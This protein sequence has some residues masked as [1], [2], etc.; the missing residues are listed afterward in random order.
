VQLETLLDDHRLWPAL[1]VGASISIGLAGLL[2]EGFK[3]RR[4]PPAPRWLGRALSAWAVG[5]SPGLLG[6]VLLA[7]VGLDAQQTAI[8]AVATVLSC[9]VVGTALDL[10]T[11]VGGVSA[12]L[13]LLDDAA[14]LGRVAEISEKLGVDPPVC[15]LLRSSSASQVALAWAGGLVRPT[16][17][18]TDGILHRLS[19]DERDAILAHEIAHLA[20]GSIWWL[21]LTVPVSACACVL[22]AVAL[23]LPVAA[24]LALGAALFVG[25]RRLVQRPSEIACDVRAG[26]AVGHVAMAGAL[27]KIHAV[28]VLA[29]EGLVPLVVHATATHPAKAVRL[30]ALRRD[31]PACVR[32][33]IPPVES[34]A[35]VHRLAGR[36]ALAGWALLVVA[37]MASLAL[38]EPP[39]VGAAIAL[40]AVACAPM[41]VVLLAVMRRLRRH[42][43]RTRVRTPGMRLLV[44]GVLAVAA[45]LVTGT[46]NVFK[47]PL[48]VLLLALA[49]AVVALVGALRL[50][51]CQALRAKVLLRLQAAEHA[52]VLALAEKRASELRRDPL[53]AYLVAFAASRSGQRER[54]VSELSRLAA[55]PVRLGA[56]ALML[57]DMVLEE[58]PQ[59][60]LEAARS[61]RSRLPGDPLALALQAR[62]LRALRRLDEAQRVADEGLRLEPR[63]SQLLAVSASIALD[64]GRLGRAR[65]LAD[66]ALRASPGD[67]H[68]LVARAEVAAAGPDLD[69]PR[70][71]EEAARAVAANPHVWL[72]STIER[73]RARLA[74]VSGTARPEVP[75]GV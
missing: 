29:T 75:A 39:P 9:S 57:A 41:L 11:R 23:E 34:T 31:A 59:R 18:V 30:A 74:G 48:T 60:A 42:A 73:M 32:E 12:S 26:R 22:A 37:S 68:A 25:I 72:D 64:R 69:A 65:H 2:F 62:S 16:L 45:G 50:R 24:T 56:A 7:A 27:D 36:V 28:H 21:T 15:R 17:V 47:W 44:G 51:S 19:E 3:L 43:R 49:G 63:D 8:A 5:A 46:T 40:A 14:L 33:S 38:V 66:D 52:G 54:A 55:P 6:L 35:R 70:H 61:A 71:V 4:D 20:T 58:D 53:L 10:R 67:V 1:I 13:P